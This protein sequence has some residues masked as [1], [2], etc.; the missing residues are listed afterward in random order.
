MWNLRPGVGDDDSYSGTQQ[1]L[2]PLIIHDGVGPIA[3]FYKIRL[4]NLIPDICK[5]GLQIVCHGSINLSF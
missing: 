3:I 1:V 2:E 5:Y 4:I